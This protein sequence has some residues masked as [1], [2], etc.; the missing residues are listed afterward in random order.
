MNAKFTNEAS[1]RNRALTPWWAT[2]RDEAALLSRPGTHHKA[3]L[4]QAHALH[5]RKIING[6]ELSDFLELADGDLAY[7][8]EKLLD[9]RCPGQEGF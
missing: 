3:L 7:A 2:L 8:V 6:D 9:E 1:C 5:V 4:D